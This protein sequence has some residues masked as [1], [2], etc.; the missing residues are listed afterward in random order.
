MVQNQVRP[1]PVPEEELPPEVKVLTGPVPVKELPPEV[2]AVAEPPSGLW[3]G[4]KTGVQTVWQDVRGTASMLGLTKPKAPEPERPGRSILDVNSVGGFFDWLVTNLAEQGP[5]M[6]AV[7]G[8]GFAGA[9]SGAAVGSLLGGPAGAA[10]GAVAGGALA[11]L[12]GAFALNAGETY[13][14]LTG[15]GVPH[16]KAR[17][18]AIPIGGAKALLDVVTPLK[19][20]GKLILFPRKALSEA[21]ASKATSPFFKHVAAK[22]LEGALTEVPTEVAQEFLDIA[23]ARKNKIPVTGEEVLERV[24]NAGAAAAAAGGLFGGATGVAERVPAP[25]AAAKAGQEL[26]KLETIST[27]SRS[28]RLKT[29]AAVVDTGLVTPGEKLDELTIRAAPLAE[30]IREALPEGVKTPHL[31][32]GPQ[33]AFEMQTEEGPRSLLHVNDLNP[34]DLPASV[35]TAVKEVMGV[36]IPAEKLAPLSRPELIPI[37]RQ[38]QSASNERTLRFAQ[39]NEVLERLVALSSGSK[40]RRAILDLVNTLGYEHIQLPQAEFNLPNGR[41]AEVFQVGEGGPRPIE[42]SSFS[43]NFETPPTAVREWL[44]AVD[45]SVQLALNAAAQFAPQSF[46]PLVEQYRG[47]RLGVAWPDNAT[48]MRLDPRLDERGGFSI[49]VGPSAA[50]RPDQLISAIAHEM[51][52]TISPLHGSQSFVQSLAASLQAISS[53]RPQIEARVG[54]ALQEIAGLAGVSTPE[55]A[56]GKLAAG[57]YEFTQDRAKNLPRTGQLRS[58]SEYES[59][60]S[61]AG[62]FHS[63]KWDFMYQ[64]YL[65]MTEQLKLKA[66]F[67]DTTGLYTG[68]EL[69][70]LTQK[71]RSLMEAYADFW[72]KTSPAPRL[73]PPPL[74]IGFGVTP[75][76]KTSYGVLPIVRASGLFVASSTGTPIPQDARASTILADLA[77]LYGPEEWVKAVGD[78]SFSVL[79]G[80]II[81][82]AR[83]LGDELFKHLHRAVAL[84]FDPINSRWWAQLASPMSQFPQK[85]DLL[86]WF[87]EEPGHEYLLRYPDPTGSYYLIPHPEGVRNGE[88]EAVFG[89]FDPTGRGAT[90]YFVAEPTPDALNAAFGHLK[91]VSKVMEFLRK[92]TDA[93]LRQIPKSGPLM[94]KYQK[95]PRVKLA[96]SLGLKEAPKAY[97]YFIHRW[98]ESETTVVFTGGHFLYAWLRTH[99]PQFSLA[100]WSLEVVD[101]VIHELSHIMASGHG[102]EFTQAYQELDATDPLLKFKLSS[103][104]EDL[105]VEMAGGGQRSPGELRNTV[106]QMWRDT[107][108]AAKALQ[109]RPVDRSEI[110]TQHYRRVYDASAKLLS[111][112]RKAASGGGQGQGLPGRAGVHQ[113]PGPVGPQ[114]S[115]Q[116]RGR[117]ASGGRGRGPA[118]GPSTTAPPRR[119]PPKM[120]GIERWL[121]PSR[122]GRGSWPEYSAD[123]AYFRHIPDAKPVEPDPQLS[124]FVGVKALPGSVQGDVRDA[125][126]RF[127]WFSKW[128]LHILQ[129]ADRNQHIEPLQRYVD[130]ARGKWL[131]YKTSI[132]K[133]AY[134]RL[135]EWSQLGVRRANILSEMLLQAT[136]QSETLRRPLTEEEIGELARKL[137]ADEEVVGAFHRVLGDLRWVLDTLEHELIDESDRLGGDAIDKYLRQT[138]IRIEF[139]KLRDRTYFPMARFGKYMVVVKALGPLTYE[140]RR[141]KAGDTVEV[142]AWESLREARAYQSELAGRFPANATQARVQMAQDAVYSFT[143]FPPSLFRH[144]AAKL[145][146]SQDQKQLLRDIMY[147]YAPGR[148]FVKHLRR[149]R[150]LKGFSRDAQ[151]AYAGYMRAASNHLPRLKYRWEL[152]QAIDGVKAMAS[153]QPLDSVSYDRLVGEMN[154]HYDY[155]MN[156]GNEFAALRGGLFLWF[157]GF[158][159]KQILVNLTQL[160]LF[161]YPY[162][163][164]A[165]GDLQTVKELGRAIAHVARPGRQA[166]NLADV[167][168]A[169]NR[170][171]REGFINESYATEVSAYAERQLMMRALPLDLRDRVLKPLLD[172]ATAGF[173]LSEEFMRRVT[174]IAAYRLAVSKGSD[175]ESAFRDARKAVDDTMFEYS[176]IARPRMMRGLAAPLFVFR[177]FMQ[178]ALY[179]SFT[180]KDGQFNLKSKGGWR[181]WLGMGLL[182]GVAGLPFAKNASDLLKLLITKSKE[183]LGLKDPYTD[184]LLETRR[185]LAELGTNPDYLVDGLSK[186]SLGLTAM[187]H[188]FGAPFPAFNIAPSIQMGYIIPTEPIVAG[189]LGEREWKEAVLGAI[190]ET[191]GAG[192]STMT[193]AAKALMAHGPDS[194]YALRTAAPAIVRNMARAAEYLSLGAATD[195]NGRV[196]VRFDP[197]NPGHLAEIFGQALG[198]QPTRVAVEAERNIVLY[199][200]VRYYTGRRSAILAAYTRAIATRDREAAA[201]ARREIVEFNRNAPREFRITAKELAESLRTRVKNVELR[202]R[203]YP[204]AKGLVPLGRELKQAFPPLPARRPPTAQ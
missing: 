156:P 64:D 109:G 116:G 190:L 1:V 165:Y 122:F 182:G 108:K 38:L 147:R 42:R 162:L 86:R 189:L 67:I 72:K 79:H 125:T 112:I 70:A 123:D 17:D 73:P 4:L 172:W 98:A 96:Y 117:A 7:A 124:D 120:V 178:N 16:E 158:N 62:E 127:G 48:V 121:N 101:T 130:V 142:T 76:V 95:A 201:D 37:V 91:N 29:P 132:T 110:V 118:P 200:I 24:I 18:T 92:A 138:E 145:D 56:L 198:F 39:A 45:D 107:E 71:L 69:A 44:A 155:L 202:L 75:E 36:E 61:E 186:Y 105:I 15:R 176:R 30:A 199:D 103:E 171:V 157:F 115:A 54:Q 47:V 161:T 104:L 57:L 58:I 204:Q 180:G 128:A 19:V 163:A 143:G 9:R 133:M 93:Y 119:P 59:L 149:R 34:E 114:A 8:P 82:A 20:A 183:L 28:E 5:Y 21:V 187:E 88:W 168:G 148:G 60:W 185:L 12:A 65:E 50:L 136:E 46:G 66:G 6:A 78:P 146:L 33:V 97:A 23:A 27:E 89:Q 55:E 113:A 13:N 126:A 137:G 194:L 32:I 129:W 139:G 80:E 41:T 74:Q 166:Q 90:T 26:V 52:H 68:P 141:F 135:T 25:E 131:P 53:A 164:D 83:D 99:T 192:A 100:K 174:F 152:E 181:Y 63:T 31:A 159:P 111:A 154:R 3:E 40:A 51:A 188:L 151:R 191:A 2:R 102:Q 35:R 173:R 169:L 203:G 193:T 144:L 179:Y 14:E 184:L 22:V 10:V 43:D 195:S 106:V 94:Q 177:L 140:G 197:H 11:T 85:I 160:P 84:S 175:P 81:Q 49:S 134:E 77:T 196:V 153:E 87:V 150:G 167:A 170:A